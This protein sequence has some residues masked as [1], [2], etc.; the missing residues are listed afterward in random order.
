M[1]L[2][3]VPQVSA[4]PT[5]S[6]ARL[7]HASAYGQVGCGLV[8]HGERHADAAPDFVCGAEID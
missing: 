3:V 5:S 2:S 4:L 1:T 6:G 8:L 7:L